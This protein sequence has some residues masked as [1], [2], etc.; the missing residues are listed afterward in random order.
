MGSASEQCAKCHTWQS[1]TGM[2]AGCVGPRECWSRRCCCQAPPSARRA[3]GC[4]AAQSPGRASQ[5]CGAVLA[6]PSARAHRWHP[7]LWVMC[8]PQRARVTPALAGLSVPQPVWTRSP[9]P[10]G[11]S[12]H[13]CCQ[14]KVR[15]KLVKAE[16]LAGPRAGALLPFYILKQSLGTFNSASMLTL[17][18]VTRGKV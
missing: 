11:A 15:A 16:P 17:L 18:A 10:A 1:G 2:A 6:P 9:P 8:S 4:S 13:L 12:L 14:A 3:R 5:G 7:G